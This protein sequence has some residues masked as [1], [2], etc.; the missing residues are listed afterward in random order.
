[1]TEQMI[2]REHYQNPVGISPFIYIGHTCNNNCIFCFEKDLI[3]TDKGVKNLEKEIKAVRE[4]FDFIN[5]MGKEPTLRED[6]FDLVKYAKKLKFKQIGVTTNG[7]MFSYVDFTKKILQNGLNQIVVTVAGHTEKMHEFHTLAKGSFGQTLEGIKN[8][9]FY[10]NNSTSLVLNVMITQKNYKLLL[11]IVKY[12]ID[13]G[14]KEINIGHI[15]PFNKNIKKSKE[16]IAKMIDVVPYLIKIQNKYGE[17]VK[18]L[19]VEYPPCVFSEEYRYLSF[20]CLEESPQKIHFS[21]C[22]KCQFK[23]QCDGVHKYYIDL[24]GEKEFKL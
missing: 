21:L 17:L 2:K 11:V 20:P 16:I 5:F 7:R 4:K 9:I 3:F 8:I 14:V 12:Y 10:K 18:F 22:K 13:L 1:M 24:Y 15:L 6:I 19:F 23:K